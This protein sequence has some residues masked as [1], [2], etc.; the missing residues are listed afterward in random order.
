[1]VVFRAGLGQARSWICEARA[2]TVALKAG[3]VDHDNCDKNNS[4][5]AEGFTA[6]W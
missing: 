3:A 6:Y 5:L 4:S 2:A 1:M